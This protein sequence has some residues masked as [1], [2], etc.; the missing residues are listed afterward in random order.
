MNAK[1]EEAGRSGG[2]VVMPENHNRDRK[3]RFLK[4]MAI[5]EIVR[6]AKR[7]KSMSNRRAKS[8][9]KLELWEVIARLKARS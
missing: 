4:Y 3:R 7:A 8:P 9:R 1:T 5:E 2:L 6:D